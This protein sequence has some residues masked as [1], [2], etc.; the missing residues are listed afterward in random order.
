[1]N[2]RQQ[3]LSRRTMVAGVGT[4]GALTA[5]ATLLPAPKP[6]P[7]DTPKTLPTVVETGGYRETDHVLHYYRTTLV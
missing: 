6:G 7:S 3:K 1:M 2:D 4:V 5:A